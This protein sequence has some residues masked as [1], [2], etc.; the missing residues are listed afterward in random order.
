MYTLTIVLSPIHSLKF[1]QKIRILLHGGKGV[2]EA[3]ANSGKK[4]AEE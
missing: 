3:A 4:E 1:A 2:K